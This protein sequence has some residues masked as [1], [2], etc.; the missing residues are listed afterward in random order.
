MHPAYLSL[1]YLLTTAMLLD[2][3][4]EYHRSIEMTEGMAVD[5]ETGK[6][7]EKLEDMPSCLDAV[8]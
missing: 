1:A 3:W 8:R 4:V 7:P 5:I 6:S 2:S